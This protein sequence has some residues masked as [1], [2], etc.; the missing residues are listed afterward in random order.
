M[1]LRDLEDERK[2]LESICEDKIGEYT[3]KR[4]GIGKEF[5]SKAGHLK[6]MLAEYFATVPH[7]TTKA[8]SESYRL[9]TGKLVLKKREPAYVRDDQALVDWL[10]RT[11]NKDYIKQTEKP[12]WDE[13]KKRTTVDSGQLIFADTGELIEGVTVEDRPPEFQVDIGR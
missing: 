5:D 9:A 6:A 11:G 8:G 13:L 4:E 10:K 7:K 2:R 3:R 1:G 12:I